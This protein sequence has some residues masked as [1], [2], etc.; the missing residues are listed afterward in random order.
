MAGL[1]Q[2]AALVLDLESVR[3]IGFDAGHGGCNIFDARKGNV[4]QAR[5]SDFIGGYGKAPGLGYLFSS[6]QSILARFTNCHL[7]L[8]GIEFK[9]DS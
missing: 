8:L 7:E 2:A 3:I 4:I 9:K 5:D 6:G 1:E